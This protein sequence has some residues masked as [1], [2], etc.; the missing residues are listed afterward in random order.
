[1][2][3]ELS[4]LGKKLREHNAGDKI[5]HDAVKEEVVGMVLSIKENGELCLYCKH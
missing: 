4:E 1:M 2:I 3:K 5:V